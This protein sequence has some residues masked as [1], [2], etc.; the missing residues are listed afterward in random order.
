[1]PDR[2]TIYEVAKRSGVSTATVSRVMHDGGDV[3]IENTVQEQDARTDWEQRIY[4][5]LTDTRDADAALALPAP[6]GAR[7]ESG[8]GHVRLSWTPVAGAAGY[9]IERTGPDGRAR[10][11]QHGGSDVPAIPGATFADTGLEDGVDYSYRIGAVIGAE[12]PVWNWSEPVSG[13]TSGSEATAVEISVDAANVVAPLDRVWRMVGSERLTQLR[14]GD[15]GNGND[16]GTEFAEALRQA[17]DDLGVTRV[18]AHAILDDDNHV[19][20]RAAD[21][22][23]QFDFTE[24]DA[25]YDQL[26]GLGLRPVV[27]V[28]FMPAAIARDP[29]Q[30][31]FTYRG[32]ISPPTDWSEWHDVT[33]PLPAPHVRWDGCVAIPDGYRGPARIVEV[34]LVGGGPRAGL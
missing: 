13:R 21:G 14:F 33:A 5:R 23:L 11:V 12:Y 24:I 26:L 3:S 4:R 17:H 32:I 28:S 29:E 15:D 20:T 16:I 9:L 6:D 34:D 27:E 19:V 25:L 18:R 30:T 2:S 31:V 10:I 22:R 7:A 8:A 1:V